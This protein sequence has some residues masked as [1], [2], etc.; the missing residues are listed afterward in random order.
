MGKKLNIVDLNDT[1]ARAEILNEISKEEPK[2]EAVVDTGSTDDIIEQPKPKRS[3]KPKVIKQPVKPVEVVKEDVDYISSS[4]EIIEKP[5]PKHKKIKTVTPP[6]EPVQV[7]EPV[8]VVEPSEP[9][10][11][12]K[13]EAK[14]IECPTCSKT[15]TEKTFKYSHKK[16]CPKVENTIE[17]ENNAKPEVKQDIKTFPEAIPMDFATMR[18][19]QIESLKNRKMQSVQ[20][21]MSKAF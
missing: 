21:I 5:R 13:K 18:K 6:A 16:Y 14:M 12:K 19:M 15:M 10:A 8:K 9:V 3:S 2:S 11:M 1:E 17:P 4:D 20:K 7:V